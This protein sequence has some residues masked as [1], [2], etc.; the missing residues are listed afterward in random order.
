MKYEEVMYVSDVN[1]MCLCLCHQSKT[2]ASALQLKEEVS[3]AD[4]NILPTLL[5]L[6]RLP[7]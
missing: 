4:K 7:R 3:T 6:L 1:I 5:H 2:V